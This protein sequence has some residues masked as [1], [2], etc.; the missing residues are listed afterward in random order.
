MPTY[1]YACDSC[2]HEFEQFQSI[3][4]EPL[5][6]CPSCGKPKLRRLI[7]TGGAVLFKGSGFYE[8][9]YRSDSYK[10]A[11]QAESKPAAEPANKKDGEGAKPADDAKQAK[12]AASVEKPATEAAKPKSTPK[13]PAAKR[14]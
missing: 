8:T 4:A 10:K 11:Q 1:E 3:T 5:K 2:S 9:D 14:S 12:S 7:S 13:P 6:K